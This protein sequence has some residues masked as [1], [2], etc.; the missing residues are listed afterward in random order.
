MLRLFLPG[1]GHRR[2]KVRA[3]GW[4]DLLDFDGFQMCRFA[5]RRSHGT[6]SI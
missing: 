1:K 6:S 2:G 4:V 3:C 5:L